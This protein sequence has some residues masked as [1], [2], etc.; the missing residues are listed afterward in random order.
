MRTQG[1]G[2][3]T[4]Y[5]TEPDVPA[6][7]GGSSAEAGASCGSPQGQGHWEQKFWEVLLGVSPPGVHH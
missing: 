4:P 2:A 7:A 1:G 3:V 5:K 6:S